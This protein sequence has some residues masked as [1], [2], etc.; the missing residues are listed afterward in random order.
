MSFR[1]DRCGLTN[2]RASGSMTEPLIAVH[3]E[4]NKASGYLEANGRLW[5]FQ[6]ADGTVVRYWEV[7]PA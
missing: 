5:W 4:G 2:L 1:T 7:G 6:W 3:Q